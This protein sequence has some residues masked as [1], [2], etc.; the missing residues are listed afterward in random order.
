MCIRDSPLIAEGQLQ[1]DSV[2]THEIG[3]SEGPEAYALFDSRE[4]GVLK[5]MLDPTR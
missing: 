3:L 4:D 5:V 1:P 2:F